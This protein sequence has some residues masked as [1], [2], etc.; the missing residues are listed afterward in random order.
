MKKRWQKIRLCR[1]VALALTLLV[2]AAAGFPDGG[3]AASAASGGFSLAVVNAQK[4]APGTAFDPAT[5]ESVTSA[6][7]GDIVVLT[8]GFRNGGGAAVNINAFS[9]NLLYDAEK[10]SPYTGAAPFE[11][12]PCRASGNLAGW[13]LAPNAQGGAA[14]VGAISTNACSAPPGADTPLFLFAVRVNDGAPDGEAVFEFDAGGSGVTEA[15]GKRLG[16]GGFAP[17]RLTIG[18][19][20]PPAYE[21]LSMEANPHEGKVTLRLS[22]EEAVTAAVAFFDDA[23]GKFAGLKTASVKAQRG[24]AEIPMP[25]ALPDSCAAKAVL[26]DS[27]LRP[28]CAPLSVTVR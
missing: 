1:R 22:N 7:P 26:L 18:A 17:F 10:V 3:A 14:R 21:I 13:M 5:A 23:S 6:N 11:N 12:M 9:A 4:L 2:C 19:G 25:D 15:S 28:L 20:L 16:L 24:S 8:I 27:E